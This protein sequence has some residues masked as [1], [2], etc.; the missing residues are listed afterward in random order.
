MSLFSQSENIELFQ[1][2]LNKTGRRTKRPL[3]SHSDQEFCQC[4][5]HDDKTPSLSVNLIKG[6]WHCFSCSRAGHINTLCKEILGVSGFKLLNKEFDR[7]EFESLAKTIKPQSDEDILKTPSV[8]VNVNGMLS[9]LNDSCLNYLSARGID[10]NIARSLGMKYLEKGDVNGTPF[11]K[12]LMIPVYENNKLLSYE[13]RDIT[14]TSKKK[15]LY[16]SGSSVNTLF[17]IDKLDVSQPIYVVEGIMDL[18]VL[19]SDDYFLNSTSIF[20]SSPTRRKALLLN[21][22]KE[23]VWI[24]DNDNAGFESVKKYSEM[25]DLTKSKIS[26]LPVPAFSKDVG[27][28]PKHKFIIKDRREQW[29]K[30]ITSLSSYLTSYISK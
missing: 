8:T 28:F 19:R 9:R 7:D 21:K 20:G 13:G 15:V 2:V 3:H 16:P 22:F 30:Y 17:N 11:F 24:P 12:R 18:S 4:F 23:I 6:Y 29:L 14:G 26:I 5:Y 10:F 1:L 27:D 25:L